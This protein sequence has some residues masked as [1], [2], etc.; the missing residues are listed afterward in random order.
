MKLPTTLIIVGLCSTRC[1]G[2][3]DSTT[4]PTVTDSIKT[5]ATLTIG[6]TY[7]NNAD[8]YGQRA[9]ENIP[10]VAAGAT[11]RFRSGFYLSGLAYKILNDTGAFVSASNLGTG[12]AFKISKKLSADL[13][14]SHTFY[15]AYSPFLQASIPDNA[16]AALTYENW[17][18]SNFNVDYAFGKTSDIFITLGIGKLIT[19]GSFSKKDI[20]TLTPAFDVVAGTQHFYQ[21]YIIDK[22][23]QDSLLGVLLTPV[24]GEPPAVTPLTATITQINILTYNF[25]FPLAYNR[26]N[27]MFE[28]T[29]QLSVLSKH[30][31]SGAGNANSFLNM[32]FYYQF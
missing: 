10:Y 2:Q 7:S 21:T 26:T 17:L 28:I 29:Y 16:S 22:R 20:I 4:N 27:Y 13:S 25:K 6:A 1:F 31:E 19:L 24:L 14:Y 11:Y 9:L 5:K 18:T 8:Y 3:T 32:S 15:P 30:A 23:L 12:L